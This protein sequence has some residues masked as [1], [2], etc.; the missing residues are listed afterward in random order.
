MR[1]TIM[2]GLALVIAFS[3]ADRVLAQET[4]TEGT[5]STSKA[6]ATE[7]VHFFHLEFVIKEIG[8]D[9]KVINSRSY[10][11]MCVTGR[12]GRSGSI[13]TGSRVPIYTGEKH[14]GQYIDLGVNIDV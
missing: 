10:S 13:R 12:S 11:T 8:D 6:A 7:G 1:K 3:A 9:D 5:N 4:K 14:E 2:F